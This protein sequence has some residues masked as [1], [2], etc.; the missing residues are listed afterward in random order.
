MTSCTTQ[1]AVP[2]AANAG[3][4]ITESR[5]YYE[6]DAP[7]LEPLR[8]Q[9][10][11]RAL[12]AGLV[13]GAIGRTRQ[14]VEIGY[15]LEPLPIG[16]RLTELAVRL[17]LTMDLPAWRP[18]GTTRRELRARWAQLI[19]ALTGHR[20]NAVRAAHEVHQ[21]LSGWGEGPDCDALGKLA[22][23]EVFRV[24]LRFQLREQVYDLRTGHGVFQGSVL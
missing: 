2:V 5:R 3:A 10:A 1:A 15:R 4:R 7:L 19:T 14:D 17:D 22:E 6:L 24:K 8:Q 18:A 21:R 16:C 13:G 9:L 12:A 23:R 20:D 11:E